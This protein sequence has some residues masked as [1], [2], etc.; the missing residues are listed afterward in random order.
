MEWILG[1]SPRMTACGDRMTVC[2]DRM[3]AGGGRMTEYGEAVR[4]VRVQAA[5]YV[6]PIPGA[7]G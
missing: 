7:L 5:L 4:L 1:S 6:G 2:G 3:T